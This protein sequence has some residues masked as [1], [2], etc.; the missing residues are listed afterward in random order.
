MLKFDP[1]SKDRLF[2]DQYEYGICLSLEEAGCLR[3]KTYNTFLKTIEYRN[4]VRQ[5]WGRPKPQIAGDILEN[6]KLMWTELDRCR[7]QIKLVISYNILYIYGNDTALLNHLASLPYVKFNNAVKSVVDRPRDVVFISN[8]KFQFRSY[9]R[10]RMLS[11]EEA[12]RVLNFFKTRA[13]IFGITRSFRQH[14]G[15]DR[16]P[17]IPRHLFVEHNDHKDLTMLSLVIPGIIRKTVT[18]QAK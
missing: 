10:D 14:L 3:E 13:D 7:S 16:Y 12:Q 9:F 1:V 17:Y 18:V 15:R 8:P 4:S 6:L 5:T 11:D 2:Y